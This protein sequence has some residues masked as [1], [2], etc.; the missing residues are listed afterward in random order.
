MIIIL[1][2]N[3]M[4]S[5][6]LNEQ[7][8]DKEVLKSDI[9]VIVDFWAE[10]CGPCKMMGPVFDELGKDYTGKIK[11]AKLNVD[12]NNKLS[13]QFEV[14]SIP[15]LV[16]FKNGKEMDRMMGYHPKHVLKEQVDK[17]LK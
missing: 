17:F 7:N 8:F 5:L 13:E 16:V 12:E 3:T 9:P 14:R 10:W 4:V 1:A 6:H 15:T 11:F 2:K